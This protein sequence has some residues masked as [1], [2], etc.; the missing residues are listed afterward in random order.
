MFICYES[1]T[2][3]K[4]CTGF[5]PM[6][7]RQLVSG[8]CLIGHGFNSGLGLRFFLCLMIMKNLHFIYLPSWK[9]AIFCSLT[10]FLNTQQ[11][12]CF[13]ICLR[14]LIRQLQKTC[15]VHSQPSTEKD[16][17]ENFALGTAQRAQQEPRQKWVPLLHRRGK[18]QLLHE[19]LLYDNN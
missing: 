10:Q 1:R 8:R 3:K 11:F 9:F 12:I 7:R 6:T 19:N 5:E 14:I 15:M 13:S 16:Y 2:K 17:L 4:S 18:I